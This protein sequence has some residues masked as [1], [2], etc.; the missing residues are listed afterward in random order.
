MQISVYTADQAMTG[1]VVEGGFDKFE[2]TGTVGIPSLNLAA[3]SLAS[4]PNPFDNESIL[5]IGE[6]GGTLSITDITGKMVETL[7]VQKNEKILIGK[8]FK[9]GVYLVKL[10]SDKGAISSIKLIKTGE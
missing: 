10:V 4:S 9:K 6:N 5:S 7:K 1:H 2:V 8:N 3:N